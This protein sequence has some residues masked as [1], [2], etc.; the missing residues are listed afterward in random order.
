M[1][2]VNCRQFLDLEKNIDDSAIDG[3]HIKYFDSGK[4]M[5]EMTYK[6]GQKHGIYREWYENGQIK[7][8]MPYKRDLMH[9][10]FKQWTDAGKIWFKGSYKNGEMIKLTKYNNDGRHLLPEGTI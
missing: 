7:R 6:R 3:K 1:T 2:K 4:K 10:T 8:K 5:A 9:G